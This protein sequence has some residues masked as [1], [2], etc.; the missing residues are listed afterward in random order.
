VVRYRTCLRLCGSDIYLPK[1]GLMWASREAGN[2]P[3]PLLRPATQ[4]GLL[5]VWGSGQKIPP[6]NHRAAVLGI[7]RNISNTKKC[8]LHI[9]RIIHVLFTASGSARVSHYALSES[10]RRWVG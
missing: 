3:Q 10:E 6:E 5:G 7:P 1:N 9:V 2:T 4:S 8:S